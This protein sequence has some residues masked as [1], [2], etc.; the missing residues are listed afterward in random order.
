MPAIRPPH[1]H[2]HP[3]SRTIEEMTDIFRTLGFEVALGREVET[4]W[5]NFEALNI[6]PEHPARDA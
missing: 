4:D 1:G 5:Y 3:V 6:P 2:V